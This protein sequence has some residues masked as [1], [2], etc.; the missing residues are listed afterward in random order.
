MQILRCHPW[1]GLAKAGI[2][3]D[4]SLDKYVIEPLTFADGSAVPSGLETSVGCWWRQDALIVLFRCAFRELRLIPEGRPLD[5]SR[6]TP[7]LWEQSDVVEV[8]IGKWNQGPI[9]YAEFQV[10]PDGRWL[11]SDVSHQRGGMIVGAAECPGFRPSA[12]IS[13]AEG[14]WRIAL[15]IPWDTLGGFALGAQ[16]GCNFYRASGSF[17][18]DEL[19]TWSP[20]GYGAHCFHRTESFGALVV[21]GGT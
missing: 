10:A 12:S 4:S 1:P 5:F 6:P 18:G 16:W 21:E 9:R 2:L 14:I 7:N 20:T 15:E 19:L 13:P 3:L 17:H 11:V 8:F